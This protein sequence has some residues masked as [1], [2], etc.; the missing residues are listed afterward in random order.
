M[1]ERLRSGFGSGIVL[2]CLAAAVGC[3]KTAT[4]LDVPVPDDSSR[5]IDVV[6][7]E[8]PD[9]PQI[10]VLRAGCDQS[11]GGSVAMTPISSYEAIPGYDDAL[12]ALNLDT[13]PSELDLLPLNSLERAL[14]AYMLETHPDDI[15]NILKKGFALEQGNMGHA[16][17]GAFAMA[18]SEGKE[19][20]DFPFLR[21]GFHRYYQCARAFPLELTGFQSTV[22]QFADAPYFDLE[23]TV[24]G[25]LRRI[26][27][28]SE[29]KVYVAQTL[30]DE[31]TV[32]ETEILVGGTRK[33]G[34]LDFLVYDAD[35]FLMDRSA[36]QAASGDDVTGASPYTCMACH[37]ESGTFAYTVVFPDM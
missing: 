1:I 31:G 14:I 17:L 30:T 20:L 11:V 19:G 10:D 22:K 2:F 8:L 21:R 35:G 23:S 13:L 25:G 28:D 34:M 32:R 5:T 12:S 9:V 6:E 18:A 29:S 27:D 3:S 33:D 15:G 4:P 7:A 16:V 26:W 24:K 37:F 36:F